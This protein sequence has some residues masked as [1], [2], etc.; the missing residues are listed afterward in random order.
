MLIPWLPW[1]NTR[2]P[3]FRSSATRR[4]Q[5]RWS[6]P[7]RRWRTS[8][9]H[10]EVTPLHLLCPVPRARPRRA[11]VFRRARRQSAR[12]CWPPVETALARPAGA[13]AT[14]LA[15]ARSCIDLLERAEREALRDARATVQV[16]HL[17]NALAQEIRGPAGGDARRLRVAPGS[18]RA[19]RR[20]AARRRR[21]PRRAVTRQ[22]PHHARAVHA[23]SLVDAARQARIDPVIGRDVEVRRLLTIL[24]RRQEPPAPGR[25]AGR[26]Q[27]RDRR[28]ARAAHRRRRR[29]RSSAALRLLELDTGAL[30]AGSRLAARS[31]SA[32]A[33]CSTRSPRRRGAVL[34]VLGIEQ[35]SR[36]RAVTGLGELCSP[37][38]ERGEIRLLATTTPEG[39]RKIKE[40]DP[41]RL[42]ASS[43]R[44]AIDEPSA[45]AGL[46]H[47]ARRRA[48]TSRRTTGCR[49][50]RARSSTAV[51]A[52]QALRAG[53]L[54][55]RQRASICSTRR[56][57][58]KR[59]EIDG[60]PAEVDGAIRRLESLKAQLAAWRAADDE[61]TRRA[62]AGSKPKRTSSSPR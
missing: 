53:P 61:R 49:S 36:P 35:L 33:S 20:R 18:L 51:H 52:R 58:R 40:R 56:P 43:P 10:A 62:H 15:L 21:G 11:E 16:E 2:S 6:S 9:K 54:P 60:M 25:R 41:L 39:V 32:C 46:R 17:L 1:R 28:G 37:S 3:P 13:R 31:R 30:V 57:P 22:Q 59:V 14:S 29:A 23:R 24:E 34:V 27:G 44:S 47:R 19:P 5:R 8:S 45:R 7:P 55:A 26:R 38:L 4:T 12:R 48:Q 50:A 42:S